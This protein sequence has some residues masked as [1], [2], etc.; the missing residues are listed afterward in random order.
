MTD[1]L[2]I[3]CPRCDA[4]NRVPAAR[5]G[6]N[7]GWILFIA[8]IIFGGI[9]ALM[10][11]GIIFFSAAVDEPGTFQLLTPWRWPFDVR[12]SRIFNLVR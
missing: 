9:P 7:L 10:N 1:P 5:L 2:N 8:G 6:S 11:L 3:V 4:V 12:W